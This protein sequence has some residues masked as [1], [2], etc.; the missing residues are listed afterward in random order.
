MCFIY[1][2]EIN[3]HF[4]RLDK[5]YERECEGIYDKILTCVYLIE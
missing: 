3:K 1:L 4:M 2:I 5:L